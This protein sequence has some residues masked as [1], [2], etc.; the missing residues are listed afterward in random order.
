MLFFCLSGLAHSTIQT[1]TSGIMQLQIA[2]GL[3]EPKVDSMPCLRQVL[4]GVQLDHSKH[5]KTT[6]PRLPITPVI[7]KRLKTVWI[8]DSE[9]I[10]FNIMLWT[11]CLTTFFS[12]CCSGEVTVE[13]ESHYDPSIHLSY[14]DLA[15]DNPSDPGVISMLIKKSKTDQGRRGAKVYFGKTGDSLM[16]NSSYGGILVS[17]RI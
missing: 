4:H 11:A 3:P 2:H 14:S 1:Y 13:Q 5:G 7:L 6:H 10:P 15:V 12:F 17:Q 9:R 16:S 8:K